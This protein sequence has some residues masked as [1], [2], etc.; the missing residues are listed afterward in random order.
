MDFTLVLSIDI[1]RL[2]L[3]PERLLAWGIDSKHRFIVMQ[4][5]YDGGVNKMTV[6]NCFQSSDVQF[7][8][9]TQR[10]GSDIDFGLRWMLVQRMNN[11]LRTLDL[12]KAFEKPTQDIE[13]ELMEALSLTQA[14]VGCN[15]S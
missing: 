9:I 10:P 7:N 14:A 12:T 15:I 6:R 11:W 5:K 13:T 8:T 2:Q 3:D 4:I 1:V